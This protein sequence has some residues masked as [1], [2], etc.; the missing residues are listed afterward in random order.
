MERVLPDHQRAET[1]GPHA[2]AE[3]ILSRQGEAARG[4]ALFTPTGKAATCTA[5]HFLNGIG[6]DFGPDLSKVGA[7]LTP[8]QLLES[9][10]TPSKTLADGYQAQVLTL[11]D[12][13]VQ[14]GFLI[15]RDAQHLHLKTAAGQTHPIPIDTVQSQQTLPISLMPEGLLQ[16]LTPQEAADMIAY[17][18]SLK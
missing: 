15:K 16:N 18:S 7:R 3:Q 4:A 5:C 12:G 17:L 2:T 11:K 9:L 14:T 13:S 8:E 1:L 6:R 10:L